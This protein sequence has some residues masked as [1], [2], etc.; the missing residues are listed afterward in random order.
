MC[1]GGREADVPEATWVVESALRPGRDQS[2]Y[3]A[4]AGI[5]HAWSHLTLPASPGG[6]WGCPKGY[7]WGKRC[8]VLE[9]PGSTGSPDFLRFCG[10]LPP[11]GSRPTKCQRCR[12]ESLAFPFPPP[13]GTAEKTAVERE[14]TR[15]RSFSKIATEPGQRS[16]SFHWLP[17]YYHHHHHIAPGWGEGAKGLTWPLPTL[18]LLAAPGLGKEGSQEEQG[19]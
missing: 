6:R 4:R 10:S 18:G 2:P 14:R 3:C 17:P 5:G 7:R 8:R 9:S 16:R 13:P 19:R 11:G 12:A 1:E 15:P